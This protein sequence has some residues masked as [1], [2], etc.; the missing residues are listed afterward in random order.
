[1]ILRSVVLVSVVCFSTIANAQVSMFDY[2]RFHD[3][4]FP[5]ITLKEEEV[6]DM[7]RDAAY[8]GDGEMCA[9]SL[10][11]GHPGIVDIHDKTT[12]TI[13]STMFDSM[14]VQGANACGC[15]GEYGTTIVN[16]IPPRHR[17]RQN[18]RALLFNVIANASLRHRPYQ[19]WQTMR[20][21]HETDQRFMVER[22][23]GA[24]TRTTIF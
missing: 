3:E 6:L 4:D 7:A 14:V 21:I 20:G 9:L 22:I 1:M 19:E 10:A 8:T 12:W 24:C 18:I 5:L 17:S 16:Q 15:F 23:V 11:Y 13:P 2:E